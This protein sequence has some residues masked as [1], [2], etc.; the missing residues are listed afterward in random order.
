VWACGNEVRLATGYRRG[1]VFLAGDAA[2]EI[3]PLAAWGVSA[4]I[5]DAANLGWKLAATVN[6]WAPEGLLDTYHAERHPLGQQL[7]RNAQAA[8]LLGLTGVEME[9]MRGVMHELVV[10][11]DAAASWPTWSADSASDTT[12]APARR[13]HRLGSPRRR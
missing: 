1:R 8:A 4:G 7:V 11:Q 5:Q 6:G 13:L 2:H 3:P 10:Y 9:P 12:W